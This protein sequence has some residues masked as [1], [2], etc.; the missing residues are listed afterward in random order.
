M[1]KI[2]KTNEILDYF[3]KITYLSF[4]WLLTT[5]IGLIIFSIGPATY[6]MQKCY[7]EWLRL[8]KEINISK[9]F[10]NF[11]KERYFKSLIISW[12]YILAITI[13]IVNIFQNKI[14][15]IQIVNVFML[16]FSLFTFTYVYSIMGATNYQKVSEILKGAALIGFGY[17][18]YSIITWAAIGV[19]AYFMISFIP[20]TL[21][22]FGAGLFGYFCSWASRKVLMEYSAS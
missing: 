9:S 8:G 1:K 2:E 14:W 7:D 17:L 10:F 6:A 16:I 11:F 12:I 13:F 4:L 20:I 15:L 22:I 18:H 5:S 21:I 19:S 3:L